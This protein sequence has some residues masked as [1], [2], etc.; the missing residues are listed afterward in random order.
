MSGGQRQA[1]ALARALIAE[2]RV[3]FLDE[4]TSAMDT[5]SEM[6]VIRG[7]GEAVPQGTTLIVAT[8]RSSLLALI[9]RLIVLDEGRL[10]ADGPRDQVLEILKR[11]SQGVASDPAGDSDGI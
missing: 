5:L 1:V 4:P 9:N 8:H 11:N 3:L 2:P 7:I 10:V 6:Q